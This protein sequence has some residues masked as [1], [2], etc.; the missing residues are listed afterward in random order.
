[1]ENLEA[2]LGHTFQNQDLLRRALTHRSRAFEDASHLADGADNEQLEFLGDAILGFLVSEELLKRFPHLPEGRLSKAKARVVSA[3]HLHRAAQR[4]DLGRFLRLG[5]GEEMSG[6]RAKKALLADAL[7]ALLAALYLDAGIEEARRF[8]VETIMDDLSGEEEEGN[9]EVNYKGALQELA[10]SLNLP[11]PRYRIV[12]EEGPEHTKTFT[13][14]VSVGPRWSAQAEGS[15]KKTAGQA[16][17]RILLD[18]LAELKSS[19]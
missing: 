17:A 15:S 12:S 2:L 3:A 5:R 18:R 1:M 19:G 10:Q 7:E 16:A 9:A 8:V 11:V 4:L 13:L 6:G 14:E